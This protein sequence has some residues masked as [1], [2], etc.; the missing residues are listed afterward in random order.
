M[1]AL[2]GHSLAIDATLNTLPMAIQITAMM[3]ASIPAS[4]VFVRLGRRP[5]F[6]LG[7]V[8]SSAGTSTYA[9]GSWHGS[10]ALNA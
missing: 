8:G 7:C 1:A 10:F 4:M 9:M 3:C 6:W 5:G 2:V